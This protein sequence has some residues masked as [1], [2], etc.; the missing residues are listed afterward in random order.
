MEDEPHLCI[1]YGSV[2]KWK[3]A[4]FRTHQIWSAVS[5]VWGDGSNPVPGLVTVNKK[6]K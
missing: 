3:E 4:V 6:E 5:D 2:K 1:V